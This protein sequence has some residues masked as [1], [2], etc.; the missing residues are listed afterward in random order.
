MPDHLE[1]LVIFCANRFL[2]QNLKNGLNK[3][4]RI[5]SVAEWTKGV[6]I[7][8]QQKARLAL[9]DLD[10]AF[11][12][13]VPQ[14]RQDPVC[15]NIGIVALSSRTDKEI[16]GE[17]FSLG[18]DGFVG[19]KISVQRVYWRL[20]ALARRLDTLPVTAQTGIIWSR[21]PIQNAPAKVIE[22]N[23]LQIDPNAQRVNFQGKSVGI[24]R[25]Q[26]KL[27]LALAVNMEQLLTR[28]WL[29][30]HVWNNAKISPRSI[31]AQISKL[32]KALPSVDNNIL[33]VY[34]E[35][36]ILTKNVPSAA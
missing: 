17:A 29:R 16:E 28:K 8:G 34:G 30:Q 25:T 15:K 1:V 31:D 26:F 22:F 3:Y 35:G 7:S 11:G 2:T 36:Y 6:T 23:G 20:R 12:P 10:S 9:V 19:G 32:R 18:A 21:N 24:S 33:N 5:F 4:F 27:L 14:L 13:A